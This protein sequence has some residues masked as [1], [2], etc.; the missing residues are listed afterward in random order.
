MTSKP[1]LYGIPRPKKALGKEISSSNSLAFSSQLSSLLS[2]SSG[3]RT[4]VSGRARPSQNKPDIFTT[5]NRNARKRAAKDLEEEAQKTHQTSQD[6]GGVDEET[7]HRS[8]RKLQEKAKLYLAMKRGEYAAAS[9]EVNREEL[10]LVDFDR[11]WAENEAQDPANGHDTSDE[12]DEDQGE[13]VQ[14]TD[15]FGRERT[16]TQAEATR[17]ARIMLI[18]S[19]H[20]EEPQGA[21]PLAPTNLIYG[22]TIQV[23]AFNPDEPIAQKMETLAAKRDRSATPPPDLHY[24]ANS[25]FRTRGTGFYSF[26]KDAKTREKEM[27]ALADER[28]ET[29]RLRAETI[30]RKEKRMKDLE[31]RRK[32]I[33]EKKNEKLADRFLDSLGSELNTLSTPDKDE[34][35]KIKPPS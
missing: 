4:S 31:E 1:S 7:L 15:E 3:T 5:H 12:E 21:R 10:S 16:G 24:D 17:V 33:R 19:Q 32:A 9:G 23:A 27:E 11:K 18:R 14:Y 13:Q 26:S 28:A 29:E 20:R 22:D 34:T 8:K 35:G 30:L 6:I 2:A 25:E